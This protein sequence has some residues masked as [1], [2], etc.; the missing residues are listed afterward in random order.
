M[1]MNRSTASVVY[2]TLFWSCNFD[3]HC[4]VLSPLRFT[5]PK[6][7][8]VVLRFMFDDLKTPR[9]VCDAA[10]IL[11]GADILDAG[12]RPCPTLELQFQ[13]W[14]SL[15]QF[16]LSTYHLRLQFQT[17]ASLLQFSSSVFN[18]VAV[19]FQSCAAARHSRMDCA[20]ASERSSESLSGVPSSAAVHADL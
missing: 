11:S 10:S 20:S 7:R 3:S 12:R 19:A 16:N 6:F 1:P 15:L 14:A 4:H 9:V 18:R 8:L 13:T 2:G 5:I 17:C